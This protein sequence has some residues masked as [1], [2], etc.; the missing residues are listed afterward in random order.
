MQ[1]GPVGYHANRVLELVL[2]GILR[3]GRGEEADPM[4]ALLFKQPSHGNRAVQCSLDDITAPFRDGQV[5]GY[6]EAAAALSVRSNG[7]TLAARKAS[8]QPG[9]MAT[10]R[11][12]GVPGR[13]I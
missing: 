6:A 3:A 10:H 9:A 5:L 1:R 11:I 12:A 8:Q 13:A 7:G 2:A 4:A